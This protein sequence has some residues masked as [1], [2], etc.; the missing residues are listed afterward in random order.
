VELQIWDKL[1][2]LFPGGED[3][4]DYGSVEDRFIER[5]PSEAALLRDRYGHRWRYP[6]HPST[7]YSMSAYLASRLR[8]LEREGQL[9]LDWRPA[10]GPWVYNGIISHWRKRA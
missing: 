8:E 2:E 5:F 6:D 7:Q 3:F 10:T 1:L 9:D 4:L